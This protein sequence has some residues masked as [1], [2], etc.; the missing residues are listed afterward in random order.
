MTNTS[1]GTGS[2]ED[3]IRSTRRNIDDDIEGGG[4]IVNSVMDFARSNAGGVGR[5]VRDHPL[6]VAMI[7]AGLV[8]LALS[9]R[10][11]YDDDMDEYEFGER[12]ESR[13]GKLRQRAAALGE[14]VREKAS[15]L[16]ERA[17]EIGHKARRRAASAGRSS[18]RLV[19]EHPIVVGIAGVALGAAI[20]AALPRTYRENSA[21]GERAERARQAAKEAA[22]REGR[23]V[24]DAAKAAVEK[25]REAAE[26]K[27]PTA[28]DLKRDVEQTAKAAGVGT[29]K[30]TPGAG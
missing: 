12:R 29:S 20:A 9:S 14:E 8:W 24:Q 26:R 27:A 4:D 7:G 1:S 28:D 11:D 3:D 25:A 30:S 10:S 16:G 15:D 17:G 6:P 22:V 23:K 13:S 18:G 19:K 5:M 21:F 2:F